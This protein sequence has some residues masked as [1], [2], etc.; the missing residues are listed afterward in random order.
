MARLKDWGFLNPMPPVSLDLQRFFQLTHAIFYSCSLYPYQNL[1]IMPSISSQSP[2][3]RRKQLIVYVGMAWATAFLR[4]S[5][6]PIDNIFSFHPDIVFAIFSFTSTKTSSLDFPM[7]EGSP[8]LC[9]ALNLALD[10]W[11]PVSRLLA[12]GVLLL[13]KIENLSAIIFYPRA[14]S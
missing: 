4:I 8:R 9:Y 2:L 5:L 6:P 11:F 12:Q 13:K 1:L 7:M 14:A 3:G 10:P